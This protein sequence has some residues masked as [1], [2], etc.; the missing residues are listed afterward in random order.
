LRFLADMG[1]SVEVVRWLRNQGHDSV[2]LRELSLER[3]P[4]YQ[5]Q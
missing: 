3:L 5:W 4:D 2:H 1:V